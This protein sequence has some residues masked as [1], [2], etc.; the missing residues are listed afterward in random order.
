V[1]KRSMKVIMHLELF[2]IWESKKIDKEKEVEKRI[3]RLQTTIL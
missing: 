1:M 3:K 2:F